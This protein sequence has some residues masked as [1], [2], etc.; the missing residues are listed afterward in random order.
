MI[1]NTYVIDNFGETASHLS[2]FIRQFFPQD[3]CILIITDV[4]ASLNVLL[5][6]LFRL[7]RCFFLCLQALKSAE[8]KTKE[9]LKEVET[10]TRIKKA[11]KTY[12]F[13]KFFWFVSSENYLVIG[14]RDQQ[15]NELVV[16]RHLEQ[17][18]VF[19]QQW[20]RRVISIKFLLVVSILYKTEG[21][22]TRIKRVITQVN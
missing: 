17:G 22:A 9:T 12:W 13:E 15:Q 11:R 6:S 19:V 7:L 10:T 18:N 20:K 16:K 4:N 1:Y 5:T 3:I 2:C 14:G 8:R 21:M